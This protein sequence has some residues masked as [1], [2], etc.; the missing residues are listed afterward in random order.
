MLHPIV[1]QLLSLS[2]HDP[3]PPP[4]PQ[5]LVAWV[6]LG[7]YHVPQTENVPNTATVGTTQSFFLTPFNYHQED[8][9]LSSRDAI[10]VM[11][12]DPMRPLEGAR[13]NRHGMEIHRTCFG[14]KLDEALTVNSTFLFS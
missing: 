7:M 2:S 8:P 1:R 14:R 10:K 11:P 4:P 12:L 3:T 13:V 6:T 5:D 9:S